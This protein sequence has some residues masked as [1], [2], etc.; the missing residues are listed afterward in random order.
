MPTE[1]EAKVLD[2]DPSALATAILEA[3]GTQCSEGP[4]LMR[5][6][7]YDIAPGD[8]SRWIRLRDAGGQVTLTVKEIE[9]DGIDGTHEWE[10]AVDDFDITNALLGR[11]GYTPKSYQEN[12]RTSFRLGTARVEIDQWPRIPA[13]LEI[14][15]DD[16]EQVVTT[17]AMLG[18]DESSLTGEN[19]IKVYA[20]YG[21]DLTAISDL[22]FL[23]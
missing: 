10:V 8:R 1:F 18:Y 13:Y 3:G 4:V 6:Y 17:A 19:T 5:R 2:I 23:P 9:H 22:R 15:A 7:V 16:R 20:R 12:T 11:L 14:E 21:I